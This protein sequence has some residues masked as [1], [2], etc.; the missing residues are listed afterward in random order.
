MET[1][2]TS[3][4]QVTIPKPIRERLGIVPGDAVAFELAPDGRIV[5]VKAG[6]A[7]PVSRFEALRGRPGRGLSTDEIMALTRG[8]D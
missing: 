2:V 3:K 6:G 4:G 1:R 5:L 7:R 8:E